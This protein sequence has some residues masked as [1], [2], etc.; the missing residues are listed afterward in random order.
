MFSKGIL[1]PTTKDTPSPLTTHSTVMYRMGVMI[2]LFDIELLGLTE[3][4][5]PMGDETLDVTQYFNL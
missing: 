2:E 5:A 4:L 1:H 3:L